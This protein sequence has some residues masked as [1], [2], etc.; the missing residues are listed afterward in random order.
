MKR[1]LP[2]L[3]ILL[4]ALLLLGGCHGTG[5]IEDF[6]RSLPIYAEDDPKAV[7]AMLSATLSAEDG[8]LTLRG[9]LKNTGAWSSGSA[10]LYVEYRDAQQ[11]ALLSATY[12]LPFDPAVVSNAV[13][14]F[15]V[16]IRNF[17]HPE[18][19]ASIQV[20]FGK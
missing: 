18:D 7:W 2:R 11:E 19:I 4:A 5:K 1:R 9:Q 3:A 6:S 13:T 14:G 8:V 10:I 16:T 17:Y 20:E 12:D 15:E